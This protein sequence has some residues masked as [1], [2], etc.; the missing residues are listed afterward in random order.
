MSKRTNWIIAGVAVVVVAA[1][2]YV[3]FGTSKS[4]DNKTVTVGVMS[5]SKSEDEIW[6][7]VTKTAKDKYGITLKTKKFTDY[8]QPNKALADGDIDLNAFQNYPFL[9]NW[10]KQ[11]KT[12]IVSIGDTWTTPLRIYSNQHKKIS[13]I[14]SGDQITVANDTTNEDR[15]IHLLADAGLLKIK[16]TN[17]A[18]PKDITSNPKNLKVTPVDASQ[19]PSSL[20]DPKVGAA[21]INTNFAKSA[22]L[23]LDSA[24]Y[25]EGLNKDTEKY[26]NFIAA[27]KKDKDKA[28]Y[29]DVVKAFQTKETKDLVKKLYGS[30]QI[31]VWDY[32]K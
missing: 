8:L 3:S 9:E 30:S 19:T 20:K 11:Y 18:T 2:A 29:K 26:F 5:G 28:I 17:T 15:G 31:T 22:K 12:D 13:E 16:D 23:D 4:A 25:I 1:V 32:K 21:V 7:S 24:I 27:N 6:D 14:K 10:N